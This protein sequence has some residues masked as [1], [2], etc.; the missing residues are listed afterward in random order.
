MFRG[1]TFQYFVFLFFLLISEN[2]YPG[3]FSDFFSPQAKQQTPPPSPAANQVN[4]P[5]SIPLPQGASIP[6]A[7]NGA[8]L[9]VMKA[10]E[11]RSRL[12]KEAIRLRF[13][14]KQ[15]RAVQFDEKQNISREDFFKRYSPGLKLGP[16]DQITKIKEFY[17]QN[18]PM[19]YFSIHEQKYKNL[20]VF[21][22]RITLAEKQEKQ[23]VL[24]ALTSYAA[25][26]DKLNLN[27]SPTLNEQEALEAAMKS[28]GAL[29]FAWIQDPQNFQSPSATL[30]IASK[31][32]SFSPESM[33]L[34]YRFSSIPTLSPRENYQI[35]VD[36]KTGEIFNLSSLIN[37]TINVEW[38][39]SVQA[40][41]FN[42]KNEAVTFIADHSAGDN[43]YQLESPST[44]NSKNGLFTPSD[45]IA[46]DRTTPNPYPFGKKYV[47][48]VFSDANGVFGDTGEKK[49]RLGVDIFS[50]AQ[51]TL[52]YFAT[53]FY[54]NGPNGYRTE[55]LWLYFDAEESIGASSFENELYFSPQT[56]P[57][58][59]HATAL[60]VLAHE[61]THTIVSRS[62]KLVNRG[63][64]GALNESFADIFGTLVKMAVQ[65]PSPNNW[66][67]ENEVCPPTGIR[68]LSNP[69]LS[70]YL[71]IQKPQPNTIKGTNYIEPECAAA[72][73]NDY[74]GMHT[75]SGIANYWFYLLSEGSNGVQKN[76]NK[77][78][79]QVIGIGKEKAADIAFY[80]MIGLPPTANWFDVRV[81]SQMIAANAYGLDSPEFQDVLNAWHAVGNG[82]AYGNEN[83]RWVSPSSTQKDIEPWMTTLSWETKPDEYAWQVEIYDTEDN[84][85]TKEANVV[86]PFNG[87]LTS[88]VQVSLE[89]NTTY[90]W[91]VRA[92]KYDNNIALPV[93]GRGVQNNPSPPDW[94]KWENINY[95]T[96]NSKEAKILSINPPA[97]VAQNPLNYPWE[98]SVVWEYVPGSIKY[99]LQ[100]SEN[101]FPTDDSQPALS[102][103][104]ITVN[105]SNPENQE[106]SNIKQSLNLKMN[107]L[108]YVR[109][110]VVNA[111]GSFGMWSKG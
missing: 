38:H 8:N 17:A 31:D 75:N 30:G 62:S 16:N 100:I 76:D 92:K 84:K 59:Y 61:F 9:G 67:F 104:T 94:G 36:A 89:P 78:N 111:D 33:T 54:W 93:S 18:V 80:T 1:R 46:I 81:L 52:D 107:T 68:N 70:G 4:P 65:G 48:K 13:S 91:S 77:E 90:Y 11:E 34:V 96:T 29:N 86:Y 95:F 57:G 71:D 40:N 53:H 98:S 105:P 35:D 2:A 87:K 37:S 43:Q 22:S 51:K 110:A 24:F 109:V 15:I 44:F 26:L 20:P 25:N 28:L 7:K 49:D 66:L 101:P 83:D 58:C 60:D 82:P 50:N 42:S 27:L 103:P 55:P 79:Y 32:G 47:E 56:R 97:G 39:E 19:K 106:G 63:I 85:I 88:S 73:A 23:S 5:L 21:D 6:S 45:I 99:F 3:W 74:C 12:A 14:G 69:K 10:K 64:S 108:Y 102:T 41:G 72:E